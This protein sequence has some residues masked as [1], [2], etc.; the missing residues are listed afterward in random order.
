[1]S[2]MAVPGLILQVAALLGVFSR[3]GR[4]TARALIEKGVASVG[5]AGDAWPICDGNGETSRLT[6]GG[7][8]RSDRLGG[9][10]GPPGSSTESY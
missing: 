6:R 1:M 2:R 4:Q 7:L 8:R 9:T 5:A 10:Q 3:F